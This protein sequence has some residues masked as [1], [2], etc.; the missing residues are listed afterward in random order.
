M[1]KIL[2]TTILM[3]CMIVMVSGTDLVKHPLVKTGKNCFGY[4]ILEAG[5]GINCSGDTI[6]L[7]TT[8]GYYKIITSQLKK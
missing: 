2:S 6:A 5:K 7:K 3:I 1:K 4:T 8:Y